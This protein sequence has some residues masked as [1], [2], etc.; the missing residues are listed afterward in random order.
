[1]DYVLDIS[2]IIKHELEWKLLAALHNSARVA[3]SGIC[4]VLSI[5]DITAARAKEETLRTIVEK[6]QDRDPPLWPDYLFG[7][8]IKAFITKDSNYDFLYWLNRYDLYD[9]DNGDGKCREV[10]ET[11]RELIP[12]RREPFFVGIKTKTTQ[13]IC[14]NLLFRGEDDDG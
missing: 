5:G 11:I 8:P 12:R 3:P 13:Y 4:Q 9:R 6:Y 14:N 1:M 10:V 7:R 2:D